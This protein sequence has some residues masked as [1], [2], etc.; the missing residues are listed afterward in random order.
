[1]TMLKN[2]K[3][4]N[5]QMTIDYMA[6]LGIFMLAVV[7][8]FQFMYGLFTPFQTRSSEVTLVADQVSITLMDRLMVDDKSGSV[9]VIDQGKLYYFNNIKLNRLN[10][11]EYKNTLR[12]IG[13]LGSS[14]IFDLNISIIRLNGNIMN[15]SGPVVPEKVDIGQTVHTILIVNSSTGYNETVLMS[16][17]VW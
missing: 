8:V 2:A 1:M 11:A 5:A 7:F 13:L 4:D 16:V 12:E 17:R 3:D 14:A 9:N 15:Q 6:G 10:E